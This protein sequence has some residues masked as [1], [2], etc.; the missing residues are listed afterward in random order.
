MNNRERAMAILNYRSYDRM[1]V[2][3]FGFW[4]ETLAKWAEEGHITAEQARKWGDGNAADFE[5]GN[6]LGF[7]FNWYRV[8]GVY[9]NLLPPFERKVLE[10]MPDGMR[11]E[12]NGDGVVILQ[13]DDATG[14]PT[15]IDH[16]F[17]GRKEW[18]ELFKPRM[19]PDEKRIF[20]PEPVI[21]DLTRGDQAADAPRARFRDHINEIVAEV[22]RTDRDRPIGLMCGS[23]YGRIRD[24]VGM[25]NLSY[26]QA[27]DPALFDEMIATFADLC[28]WATEKAL[29]TYGD[30]W[31][32]GHFWEDICFRSG[33]LVSPRVFKQK[34][35]PRYRRIT[36]LL[37]GHG[38]NIVSLDCDGKIDALI[39][40]WFENGVNTMFPIEVGTWNA[41]IAPWRE[42]YG[43]ELRGVGGMDKKVFAYDFAAIDA[44]VERLKPLID[45][46]GYI[47]CPDHRIAPDAK[48][49]NVQYYCEQMRKT[50]G[51]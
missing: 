5:V 27:D 43:P 32:F 20:R 47:P 3:H 1:P 4:N 12:V 6:K 18:D 33:P 13:K 21:G 42:K 8:F 36:D 7:D 22:Q 17:K 10:V 31:D 35:G 49:E 15:E 51:G 48:W 45:L 39:P 41:S 9:T 16:L 34:V 40:T 26:L 44:E 14:I 50:F 46:G 19:L 30:N 25:V 11:K 23:L 29:E 28:Y 24:I 37:H 2:V 38:I